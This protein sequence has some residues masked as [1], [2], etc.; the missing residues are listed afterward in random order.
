MTLGNP[1]KESAGSQRPRGTVADRRVEAAG[2]SP[3]RNGRARV[4]VVMPQSA[5]DDT[6]LVSSG[7]NSHIVHEHNC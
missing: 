3:M 1:I 4:G 7:E 2:C 6:P 5:W